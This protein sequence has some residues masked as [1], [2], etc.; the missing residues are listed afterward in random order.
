M[1]MRRGMLEIL[2]MTDG[3]E[4]KAFKD[5]IKI[6][7]NKKTLSTVTVS[8]RLDELIA[9]KA[10]EEVITRSVIGRRIIAYKTTEKGKRII[11]QVKELDEILTPPKNK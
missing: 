5:F 11:K 7:I 10:I 3:R 8:K 4:P 1:I 2:Q 9:I 6:S